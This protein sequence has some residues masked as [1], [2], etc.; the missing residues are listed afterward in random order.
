[1][2]LTAVQVGVLQAQQQSCVIH[3]AVIVLTGCLLFQ[4][5]VVTAN[6]EIGL[7]VRQSVVVGSNFVPGHVR[8]PYRSLAG[9]TA[10]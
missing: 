9:M 2:L 4:C 8:I 6:G 7:I 10:R 5:R 1:M 3:S